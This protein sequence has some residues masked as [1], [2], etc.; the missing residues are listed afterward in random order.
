MWTMKEKL[1]E[2]DDKEA[3]AVTIARNKAIDTLRKLK[4]TD[5][6]PDYAELHTEL[7]SPSPFEQVVNCETGLI[8]NSI[9][10]GLPENFRNVII[11]REIEGLSYEEMSNKTSININSL[12]VTLSRARRIIQEKYNA[13]SDERGRN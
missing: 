7:L 5:R 3:L 12:R 2:Y 1:D 6:G 10:E 9:I 11:M 4:H 8:L 13:Y